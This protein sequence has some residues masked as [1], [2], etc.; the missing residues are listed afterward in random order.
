MDTLSN[1][2]HLWIE[3]LQPLVF[4]FSDNSQPQ[5][6]LKMS[7][8]WTKASG[9]LLSFYYIEVIVYVYRTQLKIWC[10]NIWCIPLCIFLSVLCTLVSSLIF[11]KNNAICRDQL[12]AARRTWGSAYTLTS[13]NGSTGLHTKVT[14][15]NH[16]HDLL[17]N[18]A[19]QPSPYPSVQLKLWGH[20]VRWG[21]YLLLL[22]IWC[23]NGLL[24]PEAKLSDT[25][26]IRT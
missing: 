26:S 15:R 21:S 18:F 6:E 12:M 10:L 2:Q 14:P 3:I 11:I 1:S 8:K 16:L 22:S 9:P 7:V 5:T 17:L 25:K 13:A 23:L 24:C 4:G 19:W 20:H